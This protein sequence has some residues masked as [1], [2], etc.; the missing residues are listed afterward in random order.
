MGRMW[1]RSSELARRL[2]VAAAVLLAALDGGSFSSESRLTLA[3]GLWW[4]VGLAVALGLA[5]RAEVPRAAVAALALLGAFAA[6]VG[7]SMAWAAADELAF[8]EFDRVLL[9]GGVAALVVLGARRA[10][11]AAWVDGLALGLVAVALL[12]LAS[13]FFPE[14]FGDPDIAPYLPGAGEVRLSYPVNYWNGL[15]ILCALAVPLLLRVALVARARL[16]AALAVTPLPAIAAVVYFASSRGGALTAVAGALVLVALTER[17]YGALAAL[18]AGGAGAAAFVALADRWPELVDD[19]LAPEAVSQGRS[20]AL[21]LA[22]CCVGSGAL[23][24]L[25]RLIPLRQPPRALGFALVGAAVLAAAVAVVAADPVERFEDFKRPPQ[26]GGANDVESH[27]VS[28]GS[29]GR[30]QHWSAAV[31]Q[32][33]EAPLHGEGAGSYAAWWAEH[34]VIRGFVSEAHSLYLETLGELG[35]VGFALIVALFVLVLAVGGLRALAHDRVTT[36]SAAA[37]FAA[38]AAAAGIDWMWELTVVSLVGM[39]L[40]GLLVGPATLPAAEAVPR[41]ATGVRVAVPALAVVLVVAAALPLLKGAA[42]RESRRE[43][44]RGRTAEAIDAAL[45]ARALEPWAASPPLQLALVHEAAGD[46]DEASRWID[47]AIDRDPRDWRIRL[48]AAR[49][50]TRAG[51]VDEARAQLDRARELNPRSPLLAGLAG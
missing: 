32:F 5:P 13:R 21:V 2:P 37:A 48:A 1:A 50:A 17:R 15:A 31:D 23:F 19:P 24:G 9:Y 16:V 39:A 33:R 11:A 8:A 10:S 14:T 20:A 18:V 28:L 49:I 30:W 38:Y 46:V 29:T 35:L 43:V 41:V 12:A 27:L 51:D 36:A 6:W 22:V 26:P 47:E 34:G 45:D 42:L 40:L 25:V 7:L 44:E 3:I 4:T